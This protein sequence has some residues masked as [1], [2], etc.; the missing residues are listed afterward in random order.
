MR[1]RFGRRVGASLELQQARPFGIELR[2]LQ[3]GRSRTGPGSTPVAHLH[4]A[5]LGRSG[6]W[7]EPAFG[8]DRRTQC[9]RVFAERLR[10][11]WSACHV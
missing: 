3:G 11:A 8:G 1:G 9:V 2:G 6:W 7:F 10:V 4:L 5:A